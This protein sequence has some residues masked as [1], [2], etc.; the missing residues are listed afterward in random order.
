MS[1]P[2]AVCVHSLAQAR[3]A[4]GAA[5]EHGVAV[6]L[7][8]APAA[9]SYAGCGWWRAL[10]L[11]AGS[12]HDLLDCGEAAGYAMAALRV[13]QR[14]LVLH[15]NTPALAAVIGAAATMGA[16]VLTLRPDALDLA[17]PGAARH[18]PAWLVPARP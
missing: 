18:L 13:G 9:A 2:R 5:R 8:S 10:M 7:I 11:A 16:T 1:P 17:E 6:T 15:A 14:G 12:E 4:L 3:L